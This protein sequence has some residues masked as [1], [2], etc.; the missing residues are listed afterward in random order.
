M[1]IELRELSL[2]RSNIEQLCANIDHVS[3]LAKSESDLFEMI[4]LEWFDLI[5]TVDEDWDSTKIDKTKIHNLLCYHGLFTIYRFLSNDVSEADAFAIQRDY[6]EKQFSR[7]FD[8]W[9]EIGFPYDFT[10]YDPDP[11]LGI[12]DFV[13][14]RV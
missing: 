14:E 10:E 13:I 2:F 8:K 11:N 12:S 4:R 6:F 7:S 1:A 5:E 9:R 3:L